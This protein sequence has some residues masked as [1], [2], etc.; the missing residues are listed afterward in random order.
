MNINQLYSINYYACT[1]PVGL[2]SFLIHL[3]YQIKKRKFSFKIEF[4]GYSIVV[5]FAT[6]KN[7]AL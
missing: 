7:L 3:F 4:L 5:V 2:I 6:T 1:L